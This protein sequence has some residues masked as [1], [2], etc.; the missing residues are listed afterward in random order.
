MVLCAWHVLHFG[1]DEAGSVAHA[2][3]PRWTGL[4]P[5]PAVG[6]AVCW[7]LLGDAGFAPGLFLQG[8]ALVIWL[9]KTDSDPHKFVSGSD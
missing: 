1:L 4:V 5:A 2:R 6:F 3:T 9:P 7:C 8:Q